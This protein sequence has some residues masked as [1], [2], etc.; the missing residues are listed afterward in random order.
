MKV[1]LNRK[2]IISIL[3]AVSFCLVFAPSAF[4]GYSVGFASDNIQIIDPPNNGT[5]VHGILPISGTASVDEVWFCIRGPQKEVEI[6]KA[7]VTEGK[8]SIQVTLRFG[9]GQYT[10]WA[11]DNK[12]SFD[13][14]IRFTANNVIEDNRYTSASTYVNSDDP[15]IIE[16]S[17]RLVNNDMTDLEKAK[18]IHDWVAGNIKYDYQ[19][20]LEGDL[21]LEMATQTLEDKS[22]V[23][24]GYSFLYAALS[25]AAGLP[26]RVVYGQIKGNGGWEAQRHAWNE[27]MVD[28]QWISV[29]STWDAGYIQDGSF[30]A[31][32]SNEYFNADAATFTSTHGEGIEKFY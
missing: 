20:Y 22:G 17:N 24:S 13:G 3:I 23:C 30:I 9:P 25:R 11:D 19:A 12:T 8:F 2:S 31:S 32:Y 1:L 16:L 7:Q 26:A 28:G 27:V 6:Q 21:G 10:I 4:A 15:A 14:K 5:E 29:D 18:A